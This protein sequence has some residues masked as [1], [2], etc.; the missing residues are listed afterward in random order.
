MPG[1]ITKNRREFTALLK[2]EDSVYLVIVLQADLAHDWALRNMG[3][4]TYEGAG[5]GQ[6]SGQG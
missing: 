5:S 1:K 4:N 3:L 6:L 2:V